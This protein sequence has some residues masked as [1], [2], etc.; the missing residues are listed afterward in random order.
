M[1]GAALS[2][3]SGKDND[4]DFMT[5]FLIENLEIINHRNVFWHPQMAAEFMLLS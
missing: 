3:H 1:S 2:F 5:V 4:F